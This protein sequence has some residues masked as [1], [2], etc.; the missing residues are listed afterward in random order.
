[1]GFD[2]VGSSGFCMRAGSVGAVTSVV[3]SLTP[4][5]GE[6]MAVHPCLR[7]LPISEP[8][9]MGGVLDEAIGV[10]LPK[11][12]PVHQGCICELPQPCWL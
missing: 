2:V 1:M 3:A 12:Y 8:P 4:F 9:E 6:T 5:L 10:V 7:A 11:L